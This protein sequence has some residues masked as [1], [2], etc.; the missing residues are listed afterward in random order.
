MS[1]ALG[2]IAGGGDLP[3]AIAE[4][5]RASGRSVFVLRLTN[6]TG[7]WATD[8][9]NETVALGELGKAMKAFKAHDCSDVT[10]AGKV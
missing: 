3:R 1:G 4:S 6:L 9:P 5:A 8:Y 7:E 2:I 10:L